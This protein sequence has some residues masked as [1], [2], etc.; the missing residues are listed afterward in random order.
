MANQKGFDRSNGK[1]GPS[2]WDR[3]AV[4]IALISLLVSG[5][6]AKASYNLA[7][8]SDDRAAATDA[9]AQAAETEAIAAAV[10]TRFVYP[11]SAEGRRL[12]ETAGER[13]IDL[14]DLTGAIVVEN[15]SDRPIRE[16]WVTVASEDG[17][18]ELR[19]LGP[20]SRQYAI[21]EQ[22]SGDDPLD[23]GEPPF[24]V[25]FTDFGGLHWLRRDYGLV[26]QVASDASTYDHV[27]KVREELL[28]T[29][30]G[31]LAYHQIINDLEPQQ[32]S[33]GCR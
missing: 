25:A 15:F 33:A 27:D 14:E 9:R 31:N 13:G 5:V 18:S 11:G 8:R 28:R 7:K 30:G 29:V 4:F 16:V 20:C 12:V 26:T 22:R 24:A 23:R 32:L 10:S 21:Y 2:G 1:K 19:E 17:L 6:S 3:A